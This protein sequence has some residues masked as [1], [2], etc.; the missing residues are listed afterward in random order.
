MQATLLL[1]LLFLGVYYRVRISRLYQ[2]ILIGLCMY[3]AIQIANSQILLLNKL[4]ADSIFGYI[5]QGSFLVPMVI[6]TFAIWRGGAYSE[7]PPELISQTKY[8]EM[9]P[10]IHDHLQKLNDKI[11]DF[12]GKNRKK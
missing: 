5:R 12:A 4:P 2:L 10:R 9:S 3:S 6:W 8:D 11:A 7:T 1:L